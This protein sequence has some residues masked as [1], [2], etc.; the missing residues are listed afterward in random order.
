MNKEEKEKVENMKIM[1]ILLF[2]ILISLFVIYYG[3]VNGDEGWSLLA[4][5]NVYNGFKPYENFLLTQPPLLPYVYGF[6]QIFN[7]SLFLGRLTSLIFNIL[8]FFTVY[9]IT[10]LLYSQKEALIAVLLFSTSYQILYFNNLVKSYVLAELLA[11][12]SIYLFIKYIKTKFLSYALFSGISLMLS[13]CTRI[14]FSTI[15]LP[16]VLFYLMNRK[17]F[18][19]NGIALFLIGFLLT[20]ILLIIPFIKN[21]DNMVFGVIK[22]HQIYHN[23]QS[24]KMLTSV[25][26]TIRYFISDYT[27][28]LVIL[29]CSALS[30]K[31]HD[32]S[33]LLILISLTML[34][35]IILPYPPYAEY[36]IQVIP[37]I[38]IV[39]SKPLTIMLSDKKTKI[40]GLLFIFFYVFLSFSDLMGRYIFNAVNEGFSIRIN[41]YDKVVNRIK[42]IN[43]TNNLTFT[44]HTAI[45]YLLSYP[46][47]KGMEVSS[48]GYYVGNLISP[49]DVEKYNLINDEKVIELFSNKSVGYVIISE[50]DLSPNLRNVLNDN[51]KEIMEVERLL[52]YV[53][54]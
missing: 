44:F 25:Y 32:F 19:L 50:N 47:P 30:I 42:Q 48:F 17:Q 27:F 43:S 33:F 26:M 4:G 15:L 8:L 40:I 36:F 10:K 29:F 9:K 49:H 21:M 38:M 22:H 54:K 28:P 46:V 3:Y 12:L 24:Y 7:R 53:P 39:V 41:G 31:Y 18:K 20:G 16:F 37:F 5:K 1:P 14:L 35:A 6:S 2:F 23:P 13:A 11:C 52:I 45:P 34:V 51:Y